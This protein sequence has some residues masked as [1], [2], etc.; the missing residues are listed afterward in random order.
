M[1][2]LTPTSAQIVLVFGWVRTAICSLLAVACAASLAQATP[3]ETFIDVDNEGDLLDLLAAGTITED[4][5]NELLDLLT[6]G[7]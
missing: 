4:T 5:Y 7:V 3:Y 6:R 2:D 1:P